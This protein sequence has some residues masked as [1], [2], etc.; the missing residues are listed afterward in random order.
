MTRQRL[1]SSAL[2]SIS[3]ALFGH[4]ADAWG[5]D[6]ED[7]LGYA[8]EGEL[9]EVQRLLDKG[10]DANAADE[11]GESALMFAASCGCPEVVAALLAAGA[12]PNRQ[13]SYGQTALS[14]AV[15][16][17]GEADN[18]ELRPLYIRI[19]ELLLEAEADP[20]IADSDGKRPIDHAREYYGLEHM[21]KLLE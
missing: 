11:D 6:T 5:D 16:S 9:E 21:V 18:E 14:S 19:V 15:I 7:L 1:L 3:L 13:N 2:L 20:S 10:V 12:D 4:P 17:D 8:L